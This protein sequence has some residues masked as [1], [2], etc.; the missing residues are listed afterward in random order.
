MQ[1]QL[2][3]GSDTYLMRGIYWKEFLGK[4]TKHCQ[5]S[6]R[7]TDYVTCN[8]SQAMGGGGS[9]PST[10][11]VQPPYP[12]PFFPPN[13]H[14]LFFFYLFTVVPSPKI[15]IFGPAHFLSEDPQPHLTPGP[16]YSLS[17]PKATV[18]SDGYLTGP[19]PKMGCMQNETNAKLVP[20]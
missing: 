17:S 12:H 13:P 7:V 19:T 14:T 18:I 20:W 6:V 11:G 1:Q 3:I 10:L 15:Q 4:L 9:G 16:L 8:Y 5:T 2:Q